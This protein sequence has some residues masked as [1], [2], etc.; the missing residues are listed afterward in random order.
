[1]GSS[2]GGGL[3]RLGGGFDA[4]AQ[5]GDVG[6]VRTGP[7]KTGAERERSTSTQAMRMQKW[8]TLHASDEK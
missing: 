7:R 8:E 4:G 5:Q 1:M 3:T 2:A 6:H